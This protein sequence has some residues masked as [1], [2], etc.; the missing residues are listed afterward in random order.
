MFL[1]ASPTEFTVKRIVNQVLIDRETN[2]VFRWYG[3]ST[4]DD[5]TEPLENIPEHLVVEYRNRWNL[6]GWKRRY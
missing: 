3:Y 1:E 5:T 6:K 2:Y 4:A